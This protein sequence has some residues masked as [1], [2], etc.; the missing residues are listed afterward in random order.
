MGKQNAKTF[1]PQLHCKLFV[2]DD[3]VVVGSKNPTHNSELYRDTGVLTNDIGAV[4]QAIESIRYYRSQSTLWMSITRQ[5][6]E[7]ASPLFGALGFRPDM[8]A[9]R[10]SIAPQ[11]P[12][13]VGP[14]RERLGRTDLFASPNS[15]S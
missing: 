13:P 8:V 11:T 2:V 6:L 10:R 1:P 14:P 4:C 9:T 7:E 3:V 15:L 5:A 12:L